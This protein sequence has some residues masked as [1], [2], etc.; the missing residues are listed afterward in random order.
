MKGGESMKP[1]KMC[2]PLDT[3]PI[4][5]TWQYLLFPCAIMSGNS[6]FGN[7]WIRSNWLDF[8]GTETGITIIAKG[9]SFFDKGPLIHNLAHHIRHNELVETPEKVINMLCEF[10]ADGYYLE[11]GFDE[12]QIPA[13]ASYQKG[14]DDHFYNIY[15]YDNDKKQFQ[16]FG[17]TKRDK[18]E[19]FTIDYKDFCNA[20]CANERDDSFLRLIRHNDQY[21]YK[22]DFDNVC[23]LMSDFLNSRTR[24]VPYTADESYYGLEAQEKYLILLERASRGRAHLDMRFC[25]LL[26]EYKSVIHTIVK[27]HPDY[28]KVKKLPYYTETY[29][30]FNQQHYLGLMYVFMRDR[31]VITR[32]TESLKTA[33]EN[34]EKILRMLFE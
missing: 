3:N 9:E 34:E 11:G 2:L 16:A 32:M 17:Y 19:P 30:A 31:S 24:K 18:L 28:E 5:Q 12:S 21:E 4:Y 10:I 29:D 23:L 20:V 27:R 22:Y 26:M 13:S 8:C 6:P 14:R 25:R 1:N 15:G 33:F 7:E